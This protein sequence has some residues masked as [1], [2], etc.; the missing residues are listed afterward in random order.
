M[1]RLSRTVGARALLGVLAFVVATSTFAVLPAA[2]AGLWVLSVSA[3][4]TSATVAAGS[5]PTITVTVTNSGTEDANG[6][7]VAVAQNFNV[8]CSPS[9]DVPAGG[10]ATASCVLPP[11][12][13]S[14][15]VQVLVQDPDGTTVGGFTTIPITVLQAP[16]T[17]GLELQVTP[18]TV[19]VVTGQ[20]ATFNVS[21]TNTGSATVTGVAIQARTPGCSRTVGNLAP[22]AA[23]RFTFVCTAAWGADFTAP[24]AQVWN[25]TGLSADPAVGQLVATVTAP[26][27]VDGVASSRT[28]LGIQITPTQQSV[29]YGGDATVTVSATNTGDVAFDS[30][31]FSSIVTSGFECRFDLPTILAIGATASRTCTAPVTATTQITAAF[32]SPACGIFAPCVPNVSAPATITVLPQVLDV[33]V[34]VPAAGPDGQITPGTD[35]EAEIYVTNVSADP[36]EDV[37]VDVASVSGCNRTLAT[38]GTGSAGRRAYR[39]TVTAAEVGASGLRTQ[40]VASGRSSDPGVGP[41]TARADLKLEPTAAPNDALRV[42]VTP[43]SQQVANGQAGTV[44]VTITNRTA[45]PITDVRLSNILTSG[46]ATVTGCAASLGTLAPGEVRSA[47]CTLAGAGGRYTLVVSAYGSVAPCVGCGFRQLG[48]SAVATIEVAPSP[49]EIVVSPPQQIVA[50]GAPASFTVTVT[51]R[52][53]APATEV[54]VVPDP[55]YIG[56][57]VLAACARVIGA[58]AA[59][60]TSTYSCSGTDWSL[61]NPSILRLT[62]RVPGVT[63][64]VVS[65]ARSVGHDGERH[66][67]RPDL[68]RLDVALHPD[69]RAGPGRRPDDAAHVADPPAGGAHVRDRP[70]RGR[71]NACV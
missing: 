29:P 10:S 69:G 64:P 24:F 40:V 1:G 7:G 26:V 44:G 20:D 39:C 5:T 65:T 52:G 27:R 49:L 35:V 43:Q 13:V 6:V 15:E 2:A 30:G 55:D 58:L 37:R 31:G 50:S 68:R 42:L 62:A 59:G 17:P 60:A 16:A 61:I 4:P 47:T 21:L 70:A 33:R 32:S 19:D 66:P 53:G 41:V 54:A 56:R 71:A 28:G 23:G 38:V 57:P 45:A 3:S 63:N 18:S 9:V 12:A 25:A 48:G 11:L 8:V 36:L 46:D 67:S 34:A 22:G 51:N 14:T